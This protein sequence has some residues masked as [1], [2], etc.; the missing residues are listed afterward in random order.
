MV[1]PN[2]TPPDKQAHDSYLNPQPSQLMPVERGVIRISY[3]GLCVQKTISNFLLGKEV[4]FN[5]RHFTTQS[6]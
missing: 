6:K 1:T 4:T 3:L 5:F 2:Y